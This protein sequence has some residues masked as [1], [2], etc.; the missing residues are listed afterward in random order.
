MRTALYNGWHKI[1]EVMLKPGVEENVYDIVGPICESSDI[2][3]KARSLRIEPGDLLV[4]R[5]CGAYGSSLSSNYN[6]RPHAVE[7]L[8]D[9]YNVYTIRERQK[10]EELFKDER[11][12]SEVTLNVENWIFE[13][14]L[15]FYYRHIISFN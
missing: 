13:R 12:C 15:E 11:V 1:Q 8:V 14:K 10:I 6:S 4:L 9:G 2:L 7:L 3:G 5:D